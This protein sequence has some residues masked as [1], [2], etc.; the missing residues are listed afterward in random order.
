MQKVGKIVFGGFI[1]S[2]T[3][4]LHYNLYKV[5]KEDSLGPYKK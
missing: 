2:Y 4:Y 1:T 3:L 5:F